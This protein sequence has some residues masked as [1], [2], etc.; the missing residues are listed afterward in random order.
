MVAVGIGEPFRILEM[1]REEE[2]YLAEPKSHEMRN[3]E[4]KFS[5]PLIGPATTKSSSATAPSL[6]PTTSSPLSSPSRKRSGG[7]LAGLLLRA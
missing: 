2:I 1:D 3:Q 4:I 5:A 7:W 6:T